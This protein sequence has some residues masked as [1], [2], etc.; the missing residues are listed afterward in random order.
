MNDLFANAKRY[1]KS[2]VLLN[3]AIIATAATVMV[4]SPQ[5]WL[6]EAQLILP[7]QSSNLDA[8][9]GTLGNLKQQGLAFS[10][11]LSPLKI[12]SS[13]LT[14]QDVMKK[15]LAV[16]PERSRY[17]LAA[18]T[19]LFEVK[20]VDQSTVIRLNVKGSTPQIAEKRAQIL[21][22]AYQQRLNDL[23]LGTNDARQKFVANQLASAEGNLRRTRNQLAAFQKATGLVDSA[24]QTKALVANIKTLTDSQ[25]TASAQAK[26]AEA[27]AASLG[28]RLKL[29]STGA[30]GTLR[31]AENK[32]YQDIRQKL[33][34]VEAELA[35]L[36]ATHTEDNPQVVELR[37]QRENLL[38]VLEQTLTAVSPEAPE[39]A[40]KVGGAGNAS[41]NNQTDLIVKL[42]D[43]ESQSQGYR[44]Q[45]Q[46]LQQNLG[47]MKQRLSGISTLQ[48]QLSELQRKFDIAE[49]VYKGIVSQLQQEK[50]SAFSYYPNVQILDIPIVGNKPISPK[51]SL[52]ALGALIA[53]LFGSAALLMLLDSK[54][55][56][57]KAKDSSGLELPTL[58]RIPAL[59]E[60]SPMTEGDFASHVEFQRL[61]STIS[62]M[63]L[64]SNRIMISSPSVGEGKTTISLGLAIALTD[65]GFNV[66]LVDGDLRRGSLSQR[67]GITPFALPD[68]DL[69]PI[70][71]KDRLDLLPP[72]QRSKTERV[73]EVVAQG[74]FGQLL[75]THEGR[76][77]Y[78][79]VIVDSAPIGLTGEAA[80]M[81]AAIQQMLLVVRMGVSM[82]EQVQDALEHL[83]R[84]NVK[85]LGLVLNGSEKPG[86]AYYYQ[87]QEDA[88]VAL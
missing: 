79:Y 86:N 25:A 43:A 21:I 8:D 42:V 46:Q 6:A 56:L 87:Q 17:S 68:A 77:K 20:P 10:N 12:Q 35:V 71:I 18:Y 13:I 1:W 11:V 28:N 33:S 38:A 82:R 50:V 37:S 30:M 32:E 83:Q 31:L 27:Q 19:K 40:S 5:V 2:L 58:A 70:Y 57:F 59:Q 85:I 64:S 72:G 84:H 73:V 67:L 39:T 66:L 76:G 4:I 53:S 55:P 16:D 69:T 36:R 7:N 26:Y 47:D 80:L 51:R 9:L 62:L 24:E 81:A 41:T 22:T 65:L 88:K 52:I 14:S 45:A 44:Q 54:D 74:G 34:V 29:S 63:Q 61:A 23:R 60:L 78:D 15:A 3:G 48:A 75:S 49:G